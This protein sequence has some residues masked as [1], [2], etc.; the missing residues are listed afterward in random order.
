MARLGPHGMVSHPAWYPFR[1][2]M[3]YVGGPL[4]NERTR[5]EGGGYA[6]SGYA[7]LVDALFSSGKL[8][9]DQVP[10]LLPPELWVCARVLH[11]RA[12]VCA[13]MCLRCAP[14][15]RARV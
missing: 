9:R 3:F 11:A 10:A 12:R 14:C 15:V 4:S 8:T 5:T 1:V 7:D 13:S 2:R 6:S